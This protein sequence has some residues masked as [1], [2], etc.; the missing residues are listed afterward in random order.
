MS[1]S[2]ASVGWGVPVQ[3]NPTAVTSADTNL[4]TVSTV[5]S[6]ATLTPTSNIM[7]TNT[8][9]ASIS[10]VKTFNPSTLLVVG[11]GDALKQNGYKLRIGDTGSAKQYIVAD[12]D[13][14]IQTNATDRLIIPKTGFS[15]DSTAARFLVCNGTG[16]T[17]MAQRAPLPTTSVVNNIASYNDTTGTLKDSG[18]SATSVVTAGSSPTLGT[19]T[20]TTGLL[21]PTSGG[22]PA[23]LD[24]YEVFQ[25]TI[26]WSGIWASSITANVTYVRLGRQVTVTFQRAFAAG[27]T[28]SQIVSD[29]IPA[30]F[31]PQATGSNA[32]SF[33][34]YPIWAI[35]NNI[36]ITAY[37]AYQ[38]ASTR[39]LI[40]E[41][42]AKQAS[43]A[44]WTATGVC[45]VL[46]SGFTYW[47]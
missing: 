34:A 33:P 37:C 1:T 20:L 4:L 30:R 8:N 14:L 23:T 13:L 9:Q 36:G 11:N 6:T 44:G 40:G 39:W 29:A 45:G 12:D 43:G 15:L 16:F 35:Q 47:I 17:T 19:L 31:R 7:T 5:G 32:T 42:A 2:T 27:T 3:I 46:E 18:V 38:S 25:G 21:L 10:G 24:F 41:S 22:T 28:N 26:T